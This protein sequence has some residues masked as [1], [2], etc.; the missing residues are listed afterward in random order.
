MKAVVLLFLMMMTI[1][2]TTVSSA[3]QFIK[4]KKEDETSEWRVPQQGELQNLL[5]ALLRGASETNE[6]S[7]LRRQ[8][9]SRKFWKR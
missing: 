4:I 3:P 8:I 2:L 6:S 5:S 7:Q 1:C 9:F